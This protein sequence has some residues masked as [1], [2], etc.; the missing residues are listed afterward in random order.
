MVINW[1]WKITEK[2]IMT[3][4]WPARFVDVFFQSLLDLIVGQEGCIPWVGHGQDIPVAQQVVPGLKQS[5][6]SNNFFF[7]FFLKQHSISPLAS[8]SINPSWAMLA[9]QS[10]FWTLNSTG[11][12][13]TLL[14]NTGHTHHCTTQDMHNT[15]Q[16]CTSLHNTGQ[17]CTSPHNTGHHWT[18][19]DITRQLGLTQVMY[20]TAQHRT[21]TTQ[22]MHNTEYA[23]H[24]TTLYI[25]AQHRTSQ[26]NTEHNRTHDI[27]GHHRTSVDNSRHSHCGGWVINPVPSPS[28]SFLDSAGCLVCSHLL[29]NTQ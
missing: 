2:R 6:T 24:R 16:H 11:Q 13:R 20:I 12:H 7:F 18:T 9:I 15:G 8:P 21:R 17:H 26:D 22:D 5:E 10:C 14:H 23:Q 3:I 4:S 19:Q 1:W 25:T 28:L 29:D 27:T